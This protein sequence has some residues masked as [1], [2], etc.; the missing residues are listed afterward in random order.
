MHERNPLA[1]GRVRM[2]RAQANKVGDNDYVDERR[3]E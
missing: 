3:I 1:A 2:K